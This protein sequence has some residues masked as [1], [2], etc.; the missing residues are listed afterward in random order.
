MITLIFVSVLAGNTVSPVTTIAQYPTMRECRAVL[1]Q[2]V[3]LQKELIWSNTT[4]PHKPET[5]TD[6]ESGAIKL[7]SSTR[8]M[9]LGNCTG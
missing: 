6:I 1:A 3:D 4:G 2:V 7:I 5:V 8:I 9:A